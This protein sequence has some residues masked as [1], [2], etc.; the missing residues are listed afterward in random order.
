[1]VVF[2]HSR[3][4]KSPALT[5]D[6]MKLDITK[7]CADSLR[8]FTQ[9]NYGIKL[10]SSHAHELVAAYLV[11]SSRA[12]LLA[13]ESYPITKLMDAEIII[14]NPPILFVDHRLKTL[15]NLPSELPSSEVLAE[16]VYAPI[17]SR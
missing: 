13:D 12:A 16:G 15:E 4:L 10:K 2:K 1:M 6:A 14:L 11:Y 3:R 5:I 9:N 7:A 17:N 8:A